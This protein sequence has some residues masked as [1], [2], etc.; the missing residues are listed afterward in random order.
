MPPDVR[1]GFAFPIELSNLSARLRLAGGTASFQPMNV[2]L[3][4]RRLSA[5]QAA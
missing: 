2:A 3:E 1:K 5:H 4:S